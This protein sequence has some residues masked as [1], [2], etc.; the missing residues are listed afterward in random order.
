MMTMTKKMKTT[1]HEAVLIKKHGDEIEAILSKYPPDQKQSAVLPLL[2]IAMHEYGYITS[3]AIDEVAGILE[4]DPTQV[5]SLIGFYTLLHNEKEGTYRIQVCTD[6][7]CALR[8]AEEFLEALC[9]NVGIKVGETTE[10]GL[11]TIEEVKCL[12][13]C[14]HAPMF[15]LQG[16]DGI[17]YHEDQ[18]VESAT[19]LIDKLRQEGKHD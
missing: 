2:Y 5:G 16:P 11:I 12:A 9:K 19:A 3:G 1:P 6:L 13:G 10:D 15:Q 8:G 4:L 17:H 7:P 18:T 14:D